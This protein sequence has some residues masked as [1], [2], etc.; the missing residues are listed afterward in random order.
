MTAI[1]HQQW[2]QLRMPVASSHIDGAQASSSYDRGLSRKKLK[3][4][5]LESFKLFLCDHK[6]N[7]GSVTIDAVELAGGSIHL[8]SPL[9]NS[10]VLARCSFSGRCFAPQ[11][12]TPSHP[13]SN[14]TSW[15]KASPWSPGAGCLSLQSRP[16][17]YDMS[18]ALLVSV[19]WPT[20]GC[21]VG[22]PGTVAEQ[23]HL[24]SIGKKTD[25]ARR[26]HLRVCHCTPKEQETKK[27]PG[28]AMAKACDSWWPIRTDTEFAHE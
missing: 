3:P 5:T 20:T 12:L 17:L 27:C 26:G 24:C 16:T 22:S 10:L 18:L 8:M 7:D 25:F 13:M 15:R 14:A 4:K 6:Y 21:P 28:K 11:E 2:L 19:V 9:H 23:D 1:G